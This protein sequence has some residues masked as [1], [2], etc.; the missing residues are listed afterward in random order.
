MSNPLLGQAIVPPSSLLRLGDVVSTGSG[1]ALSV[2]GVVQSTRWAQGYIPTLG[3]AV[4]FMV[5]AAAEGQ[6]SN[7]VLCKVGANPA[8]AVVLPDEATVSAVPAS[9]PTISVTAGGVTYTAKFVGAAPVVGDLVLL[10]HRK[11]AIYVVGKVGVTAAPPPPPPPEPP[12]APAPPPDAQASGSQTFAA[13]DSATA[14]QGGAWNSRMPND[15]RQGQWSGTPAYTGAWF[16]GTGPT[17]L[18][19]RQ[20]TGAQ[21]YLPARQRVGNYNGPVDIHLYAHHSSSRPGG[22]VGR[23]WGP[24]N[25]GLLPGFGGGWF[26]IPGE[27]AATIVGGGGIS[28]A[29]NPYAGFAGRGA[30]PQSGAVRL[31]WRS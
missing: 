27:L 23:V 19:G 21:I 24:F 3:D 17:S 5:T 30:D 31:D 20:I 13:I 22:D 12:P 15:V 1:L 25:I 11:D 29:G 18:A 6:S 10:D 2:D 8:T 4:A 26:N 14:V 9:S 16:Y 28:I 7:L